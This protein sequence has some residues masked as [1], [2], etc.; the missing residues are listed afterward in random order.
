MSEQSTLVATHYGVDDILGTGEGIESEASR[1]CVYTVV[2]HSDYAKVATRTPYHGRRPQAL[3]LDDITTDCAT[4]GL[5]AELS[6]G[7][8]AHALRRMRDPHNW[9]RTKA[10]AGLWLLGA[11]RPNVHWVTWRPGADGP[12]WASLEFQDPTRWLLSWSTVAECRSPERTLLWRG[13]WAQKDMASLE[14]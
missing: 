6:T 4:I 11:G 3:R 12:T 14:A 5:R 7:Q 1:P 2:E 8:A 13:G 10:R 9:D